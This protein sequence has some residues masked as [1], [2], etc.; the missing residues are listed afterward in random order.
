MEDLHV[1]RI[2]WQLRSQQSRYLVT[3]GSRRSGKSWA[4]AQIFA[5]RA[6]THVRKIIV[7]RKFA[8]SLRLSVW[9]QVQI[10]LEEIGY[11]RYAKI[12]KSERTI[13]LPNG[14]EIHFLG[15][16]DPEKL[17]SL[18]NVTDYWLEEATEFTE[19]DFD[20]LDAGM[21][22]KVDDPPAQIFLSFNP[23]P[24][25]A[26]QRHWVQRRFF[27]GIKPGINRLV[28][29]GRATVLRTW[30]KSNAFCPPDVVR[31]LEAYKTE[32]PLLYKLWTLGEFALLKG[33]I[34]RPEN[35]RTAG[36]VPAGARFLGHGLDFGFS[37]DPAA[38][39]G[40][41]TSAGELFVK[42]YVYALDLTN[43]ELSMAMIDAGIQPAAHLIAD[44][45]EPKSIR[46]LQ[47]LGWTVTPSEKGADYKRAAAIFLRG[48]IINCVEA[49]NALRELQSWSW[50]LDKNDTPLPVV[51]DG[52]D[53]CV[54]ALLYVGFRGKG[55][56]L[57]SD[58]V[59]ARGDGPDLAR[60]YSIISD[61][62]EAL[63]REWLTG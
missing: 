3:Y 10:A 46:E 41:W 5:L 32:N 43:P 8:T 40:V 28:V 24:I 16:D 50:K 18:T 23:V 35:I 15:A 60:G 51:A 38:A 22:P 13:S 12:N 49:P 57:Y 62:V 53:H 26:G 52:N 59:R 6:V 25:I 56:I 29:N 55:S 31:V 19:T 4:I 42:E 39:I 17:K 9:P 20:T 34:L 1:N 7:L 48:F 33:A 47:Q 27:T 2:Y 30:Y 58:I 14:S 37:I 21:S 11:L 63:G 36:A 44:S 61:Q 54:D 45:A